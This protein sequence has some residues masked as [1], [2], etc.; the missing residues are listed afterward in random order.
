MVALKKYIPWIIL[1][2]IMY[3]I[4]DTLEWIRLARLATTSNLLLLWDWSQPWM[5]DTEFRTDVLRANT[6]LTTSLA[7]SN[8]YPCITKTS[9]DI[10]TDD[11]AYF[12]LIKRRGSPWTQYAWRI[13]TQGIVYDTHVISATIVVLQSIALPSIKIHAAQWS[14]PARWRN[15]CQNLQISPL[16]LLIYNGRRNSQALSRKTTKQT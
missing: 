12:P 4:C 6:A 9:K 11:L 8:I 10:A 13:M 15:V 2:Y 5:I 7:T 1:H 16:P 3:Y 14:S